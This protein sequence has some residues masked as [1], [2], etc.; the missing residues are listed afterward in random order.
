MRLDRQIANS[1]P[2]S[3]AWKYDGPALRGSCHGSSRSKQYNVYQPTN[4]VLMKF[5]VVLPGCVH[6]PPL[7]LQ[8]GTLPH[9]AGCRASRAGG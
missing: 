3:R 6:T 1:T 9:R 5:H 8:L 2:T 7:T 4:G